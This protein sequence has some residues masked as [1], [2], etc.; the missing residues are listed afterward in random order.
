MPSLKSLEESVDIKNLEYDVV[1]SLFLAYRSEDAVYKRFIEVPISYPM[2]NDTG[3]FDW[4]NWWR[5]D[6]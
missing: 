3:L 5:V 4:W 1:I 6:C 2:A